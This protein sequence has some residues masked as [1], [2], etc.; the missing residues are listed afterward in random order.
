LFVIVCII[1]TI[2]YKYYISQL[3]VYAQYGISGSAFELEKLFWC[4]YSNWQIKIST[5]LTDNFTQILVCKS[6]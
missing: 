4:R 2:V 5:N 6:E 1:I 3:S